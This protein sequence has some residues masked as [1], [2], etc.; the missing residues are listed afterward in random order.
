M[1]TFQ[2]V[3]ESISLSLAMGEEL[4]W[5][6]EMKAR[7]SQHEEINVDVTTSKDNIVVCLEIEGELYETAVPE[8]LQPINEFAKPFGLVNFQNIEL[9]T[10]TVRN[11]A[12]Y[13][14]EYIEAVYWGEPQN[15]NTDNFV[16]KNVRILRC[17][18]VPREQT[19]NL[20][21]YATANLRENN[22]SFDTTDI[23]TYTHSRK[24]NPWCRESL[25][26]LYVNREVGEKILEHE[27][28]SIDDW[29]FCY[30]TPYVGRT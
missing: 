17:E 12:E 2:D 5:E 7:Q 18:Y 13:C 25:C 29:H 28:S 9:S 11:D 24:P 20:P 27:S 1:R 3:D 26:V 23:R 15:V 19:Y 30:Q 10:V 14:Q 16:K 22:N 8:S 4:G 6:D 21:K